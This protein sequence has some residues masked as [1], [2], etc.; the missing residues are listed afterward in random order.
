ME[1]ASAASFARGPDGNDAPLRK[2]QLDAL[3]G[4]IGG[5]GAW[6]GGEAGEDKRAVEIIWQI[7]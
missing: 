6:S 2:L 7:F 5:W 4:K 1:P 3:L